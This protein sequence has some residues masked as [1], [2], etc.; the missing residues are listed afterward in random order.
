MRQALLQCCYFDW[1]KVSPAL[2]GS[3]FQTVM[4]PEEQRKGGA[5]YTSERNILK[6]I[7]PLFMDE[8]REEF[9]RIRDSKSTQRKSQLEKFHAKLGTLT[10]LD[11][12][13][14][15]GNFLILAYRELRLLEIEVLEALYPKGEA[16]RVTDISH[17]SQIDVDQFY[18]VEIE[19]FPARIAEAAMWLMDHQM[20]MRLSEAFGQAFVRLPLK[21]SAHITIGNALRLDWKTVIAPSKLNYMLGNPPFVGSKYQDDKQ[22]KDMSCVF[23]NV[24]GAGVLDYVAAWYMKAAQ[25]IQGTKIKAAFVST[26]SITQGEQ[27]ALLWQPLLNH[28]GIHIHFAHRTFKWTIDE[29][30]AKGMKVAAVY[31]VIIGFAAKNVDKKYLFEYETIISDPHRITANNINPYLVDAA[32]TVI[33]KRSRPLCDVPEI[34]FGNQPIDGGGLILDSKE[35]HDIITRYPTSSLFI[36]RYVGAEELING[37]ERFCLWLKGQEPTAYR[38]IKPIMDRLEAVKETRLK[39]KRPAT[40]ELA[41]TPTLFGFVSHPD[42]PYII[43]PSVSSERR[44]YIPIDMY[45]PEIIASNLCLIVANATHYHFGVLTSLMHMEWVRYVCGRLKSDYRY[46]NTLVY[47]NFPWPQNPTPAQIKNIEENAQA[48]LNTRAQ[49]PGNTLA[50]LYDPLTMPPALLKAHQELDK[51]VDAA[52]RKQPFLSERERIE[53]LFGEYQRIT[54]PLVGTLKQP[55]RKRKTS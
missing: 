49:F 29:K 41:K 42:A 31:V 27:A 36:R 45:K 14:G 52:Y 9:E 35:R 47:N 12:A 19:E 3:L 1:S 4:L 54:A 23:A 15:C 10:F 39:S 30:K 25:Y 34:R 22:R 46:S 18:G 20:N 40:Q 53:F 32:D 17:L 21:K 13:C 38:D 26:N 16:S 43:I 11:P 7:Q 51:A 6:T 50:D 5:H 2:F 33:T 44:L 28:Y 55:K 8:L 48:V 37:Q 24:E